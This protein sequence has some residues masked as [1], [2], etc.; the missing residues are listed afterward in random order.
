MPNQ[1]HPSTQDELE[2]FRDIFDN[3]NIGIFQSTPEGRYLRVNPA[4]AEMYGFKDVGEMMSALTDI[5][6][7]LY[8]EDGRR[9][10]FIDA[11]LNDGQVENFESEVRRHD[12]EAIWI[13]ETARV[14][15]GADGEVAYFEGFVKNI[16][17]RIMLE[18]QVAAFTQE[19][20]ERVQKRTSEL[21]LEVERRR[22]AMASLKEA[23]GKAEAATEAKSKFLASMSHELR[24]PLNAIIGFADAIKSEISGPVQPVEYG[25]YID[26]IHSSGNHLLALIN[27]V[28]DLSKINAGAV[29]LDRREVSVSA[30]MRECLDLIGHRASEAGVE[31]I[32][33]DTAEDHGLI[34]ADGRRLKQVFLNLLSNAIKFT[35]ESGRVTASI[36]VA[37]SG[38]LCVS[39]SDT[40]V[41]IAP[42]D[43]PTVLSEYGQVE[44]GL[45]HVGEG[46]GLGLPITK[47]LVELHGGKLTLESALGE[48]TTVTVCLPNGDGLTAK[49]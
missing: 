35:P 41:G 9:E 1:T 7:Q 15:F 6:H 37:Q 10:E 34:H 22:L 14:V 28:L 27:D 30:L 29:E 23:L 11:L 48:G 20:E 42:D 47:K 21:Q 49:A 18:R 31:L 12:G 43:I 25:E 36:H 46:T 38:C 39:V 13:S 24:T 32:H 4:L 16:T 44:H 17:K 40:G 45:N 3:A 8:I 5:R 33:I 2:T 26:I 19:L